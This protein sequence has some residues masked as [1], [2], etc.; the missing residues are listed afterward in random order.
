[1]TF[2][3]FE[4]AALALGPKPR[5]YSHLYKDDLS[6]AAE[7]DGNN[8]IV[9]RFVYG[10]RGNV[11]D[12]MQKGGKTYR[13]V[14]D[15]LGSVRMVVDTSD[16]SVVQRIDYDEFGRVLADTNEGFQPFGFAGGL[17]ESATGLTRFGARDYDAFTG[18]WTVKDPIGFEGGM[19]LFGY[20]YN[21]PINLD[22]P[23]GFGYFYN[24][25][26]GNK[27]WIPGLSAG[28]SYLNLFNQELS[29]EQ[30]FY[31]DGTTNTGYGSNGQINDEKLVNYKYKNPQYYNDEV[32]REA[33]SHVEENWKG[34]AYCLTDLNF[35]CGKT[36]NCQSYADALR[37]E[38]D[39]IIHARNKK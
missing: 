19:N 18:R 38:Y 6:P 17:Y 14:T 9:S 39:R 28:N 24:R 26:L 12:Y 29:H 15:H 4:I 23:Y 5:A 33:Q 27:P 11:P 22:D 20:V 37:D 2:F 21:N 32:M 10:T 36:N 30:Y 3:L 16:G 31:D 1:M 13:I 7:L 34:S 25:P 35:Q 8:N